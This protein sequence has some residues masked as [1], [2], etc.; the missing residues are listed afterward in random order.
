[1][2]TRYTPT[3]AAVL[4]L[5]ILA[6]AAALLVAPKVSAA[7]GG[8]I[9]GSVKL[10]GTAPHMKGIDMSK[11]PYCVKQHENNPVKMENVVVGSS[12]GLQNVVLYITEGLSSDAASTL[13][14]EEPTVDQHNCMY[15]PHVIAL[16]VNQ[17]FKVT[18]TDQTTHNIHP[19]PAPGTGNI[20]WNKSQPAGAPP[21]E[22][23]WKAP[24]AISV[25]CN[26]HPWMHGWH[27]VVKGPYAITDENG[28][29]TIKNVPPGSYT[30]T[31]WQEEYGTQTAKVTVA[32]GQPGKADFTFKAK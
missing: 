10:S 26:I 12:G 5:L 23:S 15:V 8:S 14:S 1:M 22:T 24:E 25:K 19:L 17:K 20:G 21:I 30:V 9:S 27:V 28:S 11:D 16:D 7:G 31:A 6:C 13:S 4:A 3:L 29:Y 18:T 2:K 32:A